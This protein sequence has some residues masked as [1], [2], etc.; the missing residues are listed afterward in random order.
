VS[1][2]F[3]FLLGYGVTPRFIYG[4]FRPVYASHLTERSF[5]CSLTKRCSAEFSVRSAVSEVWQRRNCRRV[6]QRALVLLGV[7]LAFGLTC[8]DGLCDRPHLGM[9]SETR[10]SRWDSGGKKIPGFR[11]VSFIVAQVLGAMPAPACSMIAS[12]KLVL[13]STVDSR[14][15]LRQSFAR[16]LYIAGLSGREAFLTFIFL[17][18]IW[19]LNRHRARQGTGAVGHWIGLTLIHLI[20]FRYQ[21]VGDPAR[22]TGAGLFVA[23]G[24][25]AAVAFLVCA[26]RDAS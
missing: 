9:S 6:P 23:V 5:S 3:G 21:H 20:A 11:S 24:D 14:E 7:S 19:R 8:Y 2:V 26:D 22:S 18:I 17:M 12:G 13:V 10:P 4:R 1:K 25:S 16:R 15:P